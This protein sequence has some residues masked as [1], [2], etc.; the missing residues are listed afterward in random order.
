MNGVMEE[1]IESAIGKESVKGYYCCCTNTHGIHIHIQD[2]R[3]FSGG[4]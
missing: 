2:K 4:G 1:V 3:A